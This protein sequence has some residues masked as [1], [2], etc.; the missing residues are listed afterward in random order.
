MKLLASILLTLLS[1]TGLLELFSRYKFGTGI[2]D[3]L[4]DI[5]SKEEI[6][7]H[8]H[9]WDYHERQHG[10]HHRAGFEAAMKERMQGVKMCHMRCGFDRA[11]HQRCPQPWKFLKQ[12]CERMMPIMS[13][14]R[15]CGHDHACHMR[16]PLPK[17]PKM[18]M[19]AKSLLQ[20]HG[21]CGSDRACHRRCG[22]PMKALGMKCDAL[23]EVGACHKKCGW[24]RLCH[25]QCPKM[26]GVWGDRRPSGP[27]PP[28]PMPQMPPMLELEPEMA[29]RM[30]HPPMPFM[31]PTPFSPRGHPGLSIGLPEEPSS[32]LAA[33]VV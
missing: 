13:C 12:R 24:D 7:E 27:P 33:M 28:V 19:K 6:D 30:R 14:H 8:R 16:C 15:S 3:V 1:C 10:I 5:A 32:P 25:T 31:R 26:S 4:G 22:N 20:C 2:V 18:A 23:S 17:C 29:P 9:H 21:N 11:C